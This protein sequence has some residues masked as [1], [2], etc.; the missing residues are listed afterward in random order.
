MKAW[1]YFSSS[2]GINTQRINKYHD[3]RSWLQT[4]ISS[5]SNSIGIGCNGHNYHTNT[6]PQSWERISTR[7]VLCSLK[8]LGLKALVRISAF[9]STPGS[10]CTVIDPC[11]IFSFT[12]F[13][14]IAMCL[15]FEWQIWFVTR[16]IAHDYQIL[17]SSDKVI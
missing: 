1:F 12:K 10:C 6:P 15:S 17:E 7:L 16:N 11:S 2:M 8:G 13:K 4:Y 14:S 5:E 3:L 9:C